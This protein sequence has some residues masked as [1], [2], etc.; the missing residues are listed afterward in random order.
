M[1]AMRNIS[2]N[3]LTAV[4]SSL[5][6]YILSINSINVFAALKIY[7]KLV[8]NPARASLLT[9]SSEIE[10]LLQSS[11]KAVKSL[12]LGVL[13]KVCREDKIADLLDKT[14]D[15]FSD[16]PD[17]IKIN[18]IS[19]CDDISKKYPE[20]TKEVI[21]FLWK[22]LRD[23]GEL[24]FKI[25]AIK[26]ITKLMKRK[27][28]FYDKVFDFFC[29]YIED[30]FSSK[31]V[32]I[33]L[34]VFSE[35][36]QHC[37]EPRKHLRFILNRLHLDE[38]KIRAA[39]ISCLGEIGSKVPSI[40]KECSSIVS[41]YVQDTDDE[42]R[43][44]AFFYS[45]LL[46]DSPAFKNAHQQDTFNVEDLD[47]IQAQIRQSMS[48]DQPIDF[49]NLILNRTKKSETKVSLKP[50]VVSAV[51]RNNMSP[52]SSPQ[53]GVAAFS[54]AKP[55]KAMLAF[56]SSHEDF[57]GYGDLRLSR[58]AADISDKDSDFY[59]RVAKHFFDEFIV[60]EY[61]VANRDEQH[62]I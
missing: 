32:Y 5:S 57:A 39:A 30:P 46:D 55:D 51:S 22:C 49:D 18:V 9:N 41:S 61:I 44:R 52:D 29:E 33:I 8:D 15:I 4:I 23:R 47:D 53:K 48:T 16:L 56:I 12:A 17:S 36:I 60:L 7:D 27:S 54:E 19:S 50:E 11:N 13:L 6:L 3:E 1:V 43:E 21:L 20:R 58:P 34:N 37:S 25:K 40:R 24:E 35:N 59:V 10:S 62:V 31:L 42:V 2:N 45:H 26:K 38:G 28:E 14:Y